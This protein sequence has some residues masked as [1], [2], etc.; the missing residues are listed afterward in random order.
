MSPVVELRDVSIS[1]GHGPSAVAAVRNVSLQVGKGEILGLVGESGSGKSSLVS[2]LLGLL[3]PNAALSGSLAIEGRELA[4]M[5]AAERRR[6]R[7]TVVA[8]VSQD[9]FTAL[10]PVVPIGRQLIEFQHWQAG[11]RRDKA[12]RARDM[13][14][15]VGLSDPDIRM[16][17]YP[18]QLS[19]GIRQRVA[20]AAALLTSPRLLIADE[21]TTALDAT[22]EA[23]IVELIREMR[24]MVA[25][26]IV[27][28][29][30]DMGLVGELCDRVAVMYRGALMETG[31]V[32][33]V[34]SRPQSSY[35]RA[36]LACDPSRIVEPTRRLP[37]IQSIMAAE[38]AT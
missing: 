6:M 19:G 17:Q 24:S 22:T 8:T 20:I 3:P 23:Q 16:T 32:A 27:I 25:G 9:P 33:E 13:L 4:A 11:S 5:T 28:V 31:T 29:T 12:D 26:S 37:T 10:N 7:G 38:G 35:T 2:A 34:F 30:H 15:R 14:A 18:H 21:P 36:L 1:Y